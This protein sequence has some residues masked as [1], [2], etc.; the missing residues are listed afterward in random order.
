MHT[1]YNR[2]NMSHR[3]ILFVDIE[4]VIISL[5]LLTHLDLHISMKIYLHFINFFHNF[6]LYFE[7]NQRTPSNW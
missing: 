2:D 4:F 3:S 5:I 7:A 6:V 1:P